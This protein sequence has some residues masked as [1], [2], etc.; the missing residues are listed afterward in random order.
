MSDGDPNGEG[1]PSS[2]PV[3]CFLR[4]SI[5]GEVL[6]DD[7]VVELDTRHRPKTCRSFLA[8][9]GGT[10]DGSAPRVKTTRGSP[11]PTYRGCEFHRVVPGLCVQAGD[12]ERFDGTGGSSP[13]YGRNWADEGSA[14]ATNQPGFLR[15]DKEGIL[16]MANTGKPGTNGSQ[17]FLTLKPAPHLDGG[18][19]AFG[20]VVAGTESLRKIA[21][22]ERG[23]RDK[24][25]SLQRVVIEDC[26]RLFE[27]GGGELGGKRDRKKKKKKKESKQR[28][29]KRR[30]GGCRGDSDENSSDED[31]R[32]THSRKSRKKKRRRR[33]YESDDSSD[34]D[35]SVVGSSSSDSDRGGRRK[36]SADKKCKR[37]E[38]KQRHSKHG[39]RRSSSRHT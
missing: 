26:G 5:G 1:E 13:L 8:L 38:H 21:S 4:I 10:G 31:R 30:R 7:V 22:V 25:V 18:H 36:R 39:K 17:F 24:P 23:E 37:K 6:E 16:S 14:I 28:D 9:C 34:C 19:A 29:R 32:R 2:P 11:L 20:R 15:H 27:S 3:R 33:G 12:W 35:G